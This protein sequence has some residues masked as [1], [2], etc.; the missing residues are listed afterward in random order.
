MPS[1][2]GRFTKTFSFTW[3][4]LVKKTRPVELY[5][6]RKDKFNPH[7]WEVGDKNMSKK[8]FEKIINSSGLKINK[9]FHNEYFPYHIFYL[10]EKND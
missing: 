6:K 10:L 5:Q 3:P 8:Y 9:Q 1:K 4:R 2:L 7:W